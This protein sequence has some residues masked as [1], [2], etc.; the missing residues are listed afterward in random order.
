MS[1]RTFVSRWRGALRGR[2]SARVSHR[3]AAR[4]TS[5]LEEQAAAF[6]AARRAAALAKAEAARLA[7]GL[8]VLLRAEHR[9]GVSVAGL[10]RVSIVERGP[11]ERLDQK[12]AAEALQT[13]GLP[14]PTIRTPPRT[15][16]RANLDRRP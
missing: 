8:L 3:Q 7:P 14:V 1:L 10:G 2:R 11:G 9:R 15:I 12:A 16:L 6:L 4:P 13:A 5:T